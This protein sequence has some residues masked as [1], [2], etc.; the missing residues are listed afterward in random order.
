MLGVV[1]STRRVAKGPGRRPQSGKREQFMRLLSKGWGVAAARRE[2]GVS[3]TTGNRWKNGYNLYRRGELVGFVA[4]LDPVAE[5][6]ISARFLSAEERVEIADRLRAG[7]S[8]RAIAAALGRAPSTISREVR[9]HGRGDG[10]YRPFEAH[11][12]AAR[13]RRRPR[14]ARV[15]ANQELHDVV[16]S[17]LKQRW[18]PQQISREL[19]AKHPDRRGMW[20]SPESIYRAIYQPNS[21]LCRPPSGRPGARSPLRT[22]RDHRRAQVRAGHR[23]RRFATSMITIH[24]RPFAPEDR[25]EPGHWEG[26]LIVGPAH[27]SAIGTLVERHS[28]VVKLIHLARADSLTL[29]QALVRELAGLPRH[30][31]R[32]ITWDQG[33]EMAAHEKIAADLGVRIYFCDPCSPWQRPSNE[34]TNGLLRDYFPKGTDLSIHSRDDLLHVEKELNLRPRA[35]LGHRPP[36]D[37]FATLL[38]SPNHPPL[39]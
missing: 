25:S 28:R 9:R 35:V 34:N 19:R 4:A 29:H 36:A 2:V 27:R 7:E 15:N 13:N 12:A 5:R 6:R 10:I 33:T 30:V 32:S 23:R 21:S 11:R 20:L 39:R 16:A 3:R 38:A 1:L 31:L 22:G 8:I 26:D 17:L 24:E 37:L 18:S 14:P